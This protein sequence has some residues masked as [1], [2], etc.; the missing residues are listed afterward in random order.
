MKIH[1]SVPFS[2]KGCD[3]AALALFLILVIPWYLT[4]WVQLNANE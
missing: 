3:T 1:F 2:H 4:D